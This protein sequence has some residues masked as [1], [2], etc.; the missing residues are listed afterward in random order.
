[1]TG[2]QDNGTLVFTGSPRGILP[3]TG[4]GG[5][6]GFDA[7]DP[8]LRFHTYTGGQMDVNYNDADP[9]SWLWI[10]DRF[11]VSFPEASALLRAGDLRPG[12]TRRRSSS[13]RS[14][15]GG[16]RT[17]AATVRSSRRTATPRVGE[18][19]SDLLFTGACGSPDDWPPLGTSTLTNSAATS[20]FGTTKGGSTISARSRARRTAGRMWAGTGAGRVLVSRNVERRRGERDVHAARHGDAAEPRRVVDLR[21]PDEPEPR[22]RDVLGLRRDH[23]GDA[24]TRVRRRVRPGDGHRRR[25]RTSPTTSAT[26]R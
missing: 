5:D 2:T 13:A 1:M 20:P 23:A 16:R 25:G 7:V 11:I 21:R 10:G 8:H 3:L 15:S 4:D 6:S 19:P 22:A 9:T 12:R 18:F 26:S 14:A 24:G 17:A